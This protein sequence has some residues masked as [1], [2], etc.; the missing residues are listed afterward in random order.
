MKIEV[1]KN[2]S[3]E[4]MSQN[5]P[6]GITWFFI[7]QPKTWKTSAASKWSD[8]GTDG[9]LIIDADL[10]ADFVPNANSVTVTCLNPPTRNKMS[11]NKKIVKNGKE[12]MELIPPTERGYVYRS[13]P[14]KGEPMPVYSLAEVYAWLRNEWEKLPY[15]TLVIDTVDEIN[16][17]IEEVVIQ[18]LNIKEMGDGQ[19]FGKD[20]RLARSKNLDI[21]LRLQRLMKRTGSALILLSHAK[22]TAITDGKAQL[23]PAVPSGLGYALT[24]KADVIGYAQVNKESGK[25][26]ISFQGYD[27]RTIGSR[28]RPLAQ[29]EML[30]DYETVKQEILSYKEKD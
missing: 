23:M 25:S 4:E 16:K 20:W 29:K 1:I 28:L 5:L 30:F 12:V 18:E 19:N 6:D 7:G 21:I 10:G 11:D 3:M 9:V 14:S 8:K 2:Q 24:A 26:H 15:D 13:G 27:E 17:W 22:Q